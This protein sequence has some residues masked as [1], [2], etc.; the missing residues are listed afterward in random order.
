MDA[1]RIT[2]VAEFR[3]MIQSRTPLVITDR[4]NDPG[5]MFHPDPEG[6]SHV[7]EH[8]FE[9]KVVQNREANGSYFIVASLAD[10]RAHWPHVR[11]CR[12]SACSSA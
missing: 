4:A 2:S 3:R 7:Q 12:S 8:S 10:A 6:C 11:K 5:A 1:E 9:Q